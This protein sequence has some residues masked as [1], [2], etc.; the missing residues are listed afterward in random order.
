MTSADP[1]ET[2]P[3]PATSAATGVPIREPDIDQIAREALA[4]AG[5]PDEKPAS[6]DPSQA[7]A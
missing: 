5:I 4:E 6:P 7:T 2:A 1:M 3:T